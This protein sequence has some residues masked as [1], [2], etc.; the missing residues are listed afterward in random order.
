[1]LITIKKMKNIYL[2]FI[3]F[4]TCQNIPMHF[5]FTDQKKL[6]EISGA[7]GIVKFNNHYYVVGDDSPYLFKLNNEFKV[8]SE[9]QISNIPVDLDS[10]R[11]PKK[12]KHDLESLEMISENE[13]ISFG[14]GSKS[15]ERDEFIRIMI[16]RKVSLKKYKLTAFYEALKS[17]DILKGSELNIEAVAHINGILY[18]FNRRK[19]VIFSVN[20]KD[21]LNFIE[22][23]SSLPEVR[24]QE[25]K[26]PD[27][28]GI[29]G[30]FSGAT[31]WGNS[32]ILVTASVEDTDNAY[33]D[34]EILGSFIGVISLDENKINDSISWVRIENG[35]KPL[36][37][38]S[39]TVSKENT[40]RD[41]DVIMVTDSDG[42]KSSILRGNL[43]W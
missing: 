20:Y 24:A 5:K 16:D 10:G 35:N 12:D 1:M 27:M 8:I 22:D 25:F 23:N 15:P 6:E 11:I 31:G 4:L 9:H 43:K 3:S 36:K 34:G 26:L 28:N 13:M 41:I 18:L 14:S 17:L 2:I 37:V 7:S 39:I 42:E 32:K 40:E 30:G 38:E 33:D 29:E 19:N 21:F